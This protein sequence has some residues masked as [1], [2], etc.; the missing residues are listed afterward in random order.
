MIRVFIGFDRCEAVAFSVCAFSLQRRA[1]RPVAVAPLM[2]SQLGSVFT[3][4]R[5]PLQSTD[6]SFTRFLVPYLCGYEGWAL[7]MDGDML[8]RGDLADLWALRDDRFAV[9]C[10]QHQYVPAEDTKFLG[11]RQT[12]YARKNWSSLML[13]NNARCRALTPDYVNTASGLDLHQF[14][15]VDSDGRIGALPPAWNHLVGVGPPR[16]DAAIAHY[17]IGGPYFTEYRDCEHAE[18]W[19]A[20]RLAMLGCEQRA[21]APVAPPVAVAAAE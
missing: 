6:F 12:R 4:P 8:V 13:F 7:F 20:E 10:V 18:G 14:K 3:R 5:D 21:R 9:M 17:T 1:S 19:F 15:W 2:L 11:A 16:P